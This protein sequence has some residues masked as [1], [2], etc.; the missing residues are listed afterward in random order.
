MRDAVET[1]V[2]RAAILA[3]LGV[4]AAAWLAILVGVSWFVI[5]VLQAVTS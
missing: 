1:F 4:L 2:R 5:R 3:T